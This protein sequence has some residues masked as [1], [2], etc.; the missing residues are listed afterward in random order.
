MEISINFKSVNDAMPPATSD[1]YYGSDYSIN[2][3]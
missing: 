1:E 2:R 3:T